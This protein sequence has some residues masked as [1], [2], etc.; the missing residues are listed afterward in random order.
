MAGF[1]PKGGRLSLAQRL[2]YELADRQPRVRAPWAEVE[3]AWPADLALPDDPGVEA[4][5]RAL[6]PAARDALRALTE[7]RER[8]CIE[9]DR[10]IAL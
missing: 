8:V 3:A 9:L 6:P 7:E 10:T 1:G 4:L 2:A 5:V